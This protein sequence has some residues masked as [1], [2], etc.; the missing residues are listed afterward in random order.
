MQNDTATISALFNA[1]NLEVEMGNLEEAAVFLRK[2]IHL[3]E[4]S[5]PTEA[6]L[7]NDY[8]NLGLMEKALDNL[9][10][11]RTTMYKALELESASSQPRDLSDIYYHLSAVE[12]NLGNFTAAKMLVEKSLPGIIARY[13]EN[14][15]RTANLYYHLSLTEDELGNLQAAKTAIEQNIGI[16]KTHYEDTHPSL[17]KSYYQLA[18][19][20]RKLQHYPAAL[21]LIKKTLA[22]DFAQEEV[23]PIETSVHFWSLSEVTLEMGDR[24][25]A[26]K[27]GVHCYNMIDEEIP[28]DH[29]LK[30]DVYQ[31]LFTNFP[32]LF[33]ETV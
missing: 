8:F 18:M 29:I 23:S 10:A 21:E 17:G 14:D 12:N 13:G 2:A 30:R 4:D 9:E 22:S 32:E 27:I 5:S 28:E 26:K 19:I 16:E 6:S 33:E 15:L 7:A 20:E 31:Y 25:E 1:A 24:E 3:K 11:A